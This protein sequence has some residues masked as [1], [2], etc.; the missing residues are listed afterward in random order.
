MKYIL[1]LL[2]LVTFFNLKAQE[3]TDWVVYSAHSSKATSADKQLPTLTQATESIETVGKVIIKSNTSVIFRTLPEGSIFINGTF[4]VE[5]GAHF[6]AHKAPFENVIA[7]RTTPAT[8]DEFR[9]DI[10][11]F[12]NPFVEQ[13]FINI[14]LQA[15]SEV[16]IAIYDVTGKMVQAVASNKQMESGKHQV[17]IQTDNYAPGLYLCQVIIDGKQFT[18]SIVRAK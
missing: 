12:P 5:K 7:T 3:T 11:A 14:D 6:L 4:H 16:S 18:Q 13:L 1:F 9:L 15:A 8:T 17:E 2:F 10:Q